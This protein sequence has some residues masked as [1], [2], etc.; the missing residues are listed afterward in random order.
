MVSVRLS[1][2]QM[3]GDPQLQ[4]ICS[5]L[6][7]RAV[8]VANFASWIACAEGKFIVAQELMPILRTLV[9]ASPGVG[10]DQRA[11]WVA[12]SCCAEVTR[13]GVSVFLCMHKDMA[14]STYKWDQRSRAPILRSL[15]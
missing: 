2:R 4:S 1:C 13:V 7:V 15:P 9:L 3:K 12:K 10:V 6:H 14:N 5:N 11:D 8:E